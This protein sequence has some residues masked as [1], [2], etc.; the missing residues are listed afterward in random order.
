VIRAAASYRHHT[1]VTG[2]T[3]QRI[4]R[5]ADELITACMTLSGAAQVRSFVALAR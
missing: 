5:R 3:L 4:D 2:D 1:S